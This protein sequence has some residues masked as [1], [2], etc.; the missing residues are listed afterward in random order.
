[1]LDKNVIEDIFNVAISNGG[2]F[3]EIFLEENYTTEISTIGGYIEK[4]MSGKDFGIGIRIFCG[5]N[6]IYVYTNDLSKDNLINMTKKAAKMFGESERD[7]VLNFDKPLRPY[8]HQF[9]I[10]PR[11]VEL[12]RKVDLMKRATHAAKNYGEEITQV[13]INYIDQEQNVLIANTEGIFVEDKRVRTRMLIMAV[14]EHGGQ[15]ETGYVG[16]GAL[17]G[18]EFYNTID[19][20]EYAKE[21]ARMAKT[22]V[23]ADYSPVGVMPVVIDNGFGGLM[24]HEACG[25]SL[26]A[27]SVAKGVSV[28][29]NKLGQKIASD[30]V[31]LIDDG[32]IPNYWGSLGVDDEGKRT[33]KNILI[34][35]GILKSYMVD[36]LNGRRMGL[37]S[38]ASGR[39]QSYR[40]APTSRMTNT[41]IDNGDSTKEEIISNTERGLFAKQ[42]NAGSVN[43]A[44]GDFNFSLSEAYLI[45]NGKITKPVRGATLIGNGSRILMDVDM[46]ANNLEIGQG[47]CFASSGAIFIGAGQPTIRV[48]SMTVGGRED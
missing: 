39:R 27:S 37:E 31:T 17:M 9:D 12:S 1:M 35:K 22:M 24:F 36:K 7:M 30:V 3:A 33:Q 29:S 25:H 34:E 47:Y 6:S 2:D 13:T 38:T 16:P 32:S 26:E 45:E 10:L 28:F 18:L 42:I 14:A 21:A 8:I 46:V 4:G 43:P 44:T 5:L 11:N 20:E 23:Y 41:Y 15:L 19:V 40:F 48:K